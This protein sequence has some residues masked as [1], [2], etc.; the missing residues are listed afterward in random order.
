MSPKKE[1]YKLFVEVVPCDNKGYVIN[2]KILFKQ[3]ADSLLVGIDA[4]AEVPQVI[5]ALLGKLNNANGE[6]RTSYATDP[7]VA[8]TIIM[9]ALDTI[10]IKA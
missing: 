10:G 1:L 7:A 8:G 6:E 3:S 9:D 2:M 5:E 4:N